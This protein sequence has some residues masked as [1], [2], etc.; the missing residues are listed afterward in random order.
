MTQTLSPRESRHYFHLSLAW[1]L[2]VFFLI[3]H[4]LCWLNPSRS[5]P[6]VYFSIP[7]GWE[8]NS[9]SGLELKSAIDFPWGMAKEKIRIDRPL[10]NAVISLL[11]DSIGIFYPLDA[12]AK[13][14]LSYIFHHLFNLLAAIFV[15]YAL[16]YL[17]RYYQLCAEGMFIAWIWLLFTII[18]ILLWSH[19]FIFQLAIPALAFLVWLKLRAAETRGLLKRCLT[20][21]G[22]AVICGLAVLI[23]EDY[24]PFLAI[25]LYALITRNWCLLAVGG[26]FFFLPLMG[27][28]FYLHQMGIPYQNYQV[29]HYRQGIVWLPGL[30]EKGFFFAAKKMLAWL[31]RAENAF[32]SRY[33]LLFTA[34]CAIGFYKPAAAKLQDKRLRLFVILFIASNFVQTIAARKFAGKMF[35]DAFIVLSLFFAEGYGKLLREFAVSAKWFRSGVYLWIGLH[36]VMAVFNLMHLPWISP[37]EQL[38][39]PVF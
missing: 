17:V 20:I 7:Y 38:K 25:F 2:I 23:K 39:L 31:G 10:K 15:L 22:Y 11:I 27:Y 33:G 24:A 37:F 6:T 29:E 16:F 4:N 12:R 1:L 8:Y 26:L 32:L 14:G 28:K 36:A 35:L 9:D 21:G 3:A 13:L 19:T 34:I 5:R 18:T 30:V